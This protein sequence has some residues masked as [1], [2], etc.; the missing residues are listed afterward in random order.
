MDGTDV[1]AEA[2]PSEEMGAGGQKT[3][4]DHTNAV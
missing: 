2:K 4:Q 1:E 3:A